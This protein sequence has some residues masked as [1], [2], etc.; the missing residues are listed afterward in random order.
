MGKAFRIIFLLSLAFVLALR[1]PEF[2][3]SVFDA[4]VRLD[5]WTVRIFRGSPPGPSISGKV[6]PPAAYEPIIYRAAVR[7]GLSPALIKAV[8]MTESAFDPRAVS[9]AGARGLMQIMPETAADLGLG[10]PF[11]PEA[12]I[13]FGAWL[14]AE[15]LRQYGSL[16]KALIAY[17]AGPAWVGRGS[18]PDETRRYIQAV[19]Y[20]HNYYSKT[21]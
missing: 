21:K 2:E 19:R 13:W 12:N 11:D 15:N 8:I 20:F 1:T 16:E 9:P 6:T 3:R 5:E 18:I 17:N 14:L 4:A 10:D 7:H